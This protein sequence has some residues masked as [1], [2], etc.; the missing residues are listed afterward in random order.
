MKC[1][2][3][4]LIVLILMGN[5]ISH[6]YLITIFNIKFLQ[7]YEVNMQLDIEIEQRQMQLLVDNFNF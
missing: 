5:K 1:V 7:K 6:M 4:K 2:V 3:S